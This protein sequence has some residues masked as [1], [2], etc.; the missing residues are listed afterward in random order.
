M[1]E[2][3]NDQMREARRVINALVR[4]CRQ[5]QAYFEGISVMSEE[6]IKRSLRDAIRES[7]RFLGR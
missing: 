1:A 7:E 6:R 3:P 5:T 2:S 4:T